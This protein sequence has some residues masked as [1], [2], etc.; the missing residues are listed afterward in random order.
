M[1]NN[2]SS[3]NEQFARVLKD[4]LVCVISYFCKAKFLTI[5]TNQQE[6]CKLIGTIAQFRT[7]ANFYAGDL[8][9]LQV[10]ISDCIES[11]IS[12][13]TDGFIRLEAFIDKHLPL[14]IDTCLKINNLYRQEDD[15]DDPL[16]GVTFID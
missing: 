1:E 13:S 10:A 15:D 6:I 11:Q 2:F 12:H 8:A 3:Q 16:D 14:L 7:T 5:E 4:E 9:R